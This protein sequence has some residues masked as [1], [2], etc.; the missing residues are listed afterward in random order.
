MPSVP[1]SPTEERSPK[2]GNLSEELQQF[3]EAFVLIQL[4]V[5]PE[6]IA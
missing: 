1:L 4:G 3:L 2:H 5:L 6:K